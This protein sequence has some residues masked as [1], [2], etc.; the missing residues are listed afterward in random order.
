MHVL[1]Y[2]NTIA[3]QTDNPDSLPSGFS[4]YEVPDQ[5][6]DNVYF[7]T[8]AKKVVAKPPKP[9]PDAVWQNGTL[10]VVANEPTQLE[11]PKM[12]QHEAAATVYKM[13]LEVSPV[14][15]ES[16]RYLLARQE[17]DTEY[18]K[19]ALDALIALAAT[20]NQT[21]TTVANSGNS[22]TVSSTTNGATGSPVKPAKSTA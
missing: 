3:G 22:T 21:H 8:N 16:F 15:G 1:V 12:T 19:E 18:E 13:L 5:P 6:L 10:V 11:A 14:V 2:Q 4:V 9:S 17:G 20:Y 7:D